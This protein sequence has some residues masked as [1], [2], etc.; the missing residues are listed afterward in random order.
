MNLSVVETV[1]SITLFG[2]FECNRLIAN[3]R[4]DNA[5][6]AMAEWALE[7]GHFVEIEIN[8]RRVD[9]IYSYDPKKDGESVCVRTWQFK[10]NVPNRV[11]NKIFIQNGGLC[12]SAFRDFPVEGSILVFHKCKTPES[13]MAPTTVFPS[14]A[15]TTISTFQNGVV[16]IDGLS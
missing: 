5:I 9:I 6:K 11:G 14:L 8:R 12:I 4:S 13:L 16:Y 3:V 15:V 7:F 2:N 10:V 1:A